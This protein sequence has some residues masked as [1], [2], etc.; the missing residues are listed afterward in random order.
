MLVFQ[1]LRPP[2]E[3]PFFL[4][5]YS[6]HSTVKL[7][8]SFLSPCP[9]PVRPFQVPIAPGSSGCQLLIASGHHTKSRTY[10]DP[11]A[12]IG[13]YRAQNAFPFTAPLK[14]RLQPACAVGPGDSPPSTFGLRGRELPVTELPEDRLRTRIPTGPA[15]RGVPVHV[16]GIGE[17]AAVEQPLDGLSV[18]KRG[19][20]VERRLALSATVAHKAGCFGTG[21]GSSVR[22]GPAPSS[23]LTATAQTGRPAVQNAAC[24]AVSPESGAA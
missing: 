11:P 12:P 15:K 24:R 5:A 16:L 7:F 22:I 21:L 1:P 9:L 18:P 4:S 8:R 13:S 2:R 14:I 20:S 17:R 3:A 6:V 23:T 10:R 19:G